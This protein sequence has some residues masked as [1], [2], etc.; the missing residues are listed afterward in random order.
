MPTPVQGPSATVT[1]DP[2]GF[3]YLKRDLVRLLGILGHGTKAVQD[4][5]RLCGGIHVVMNLC[6]VDE[7]NPCESLREVFLFLWAAVLSRQ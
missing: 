4:R 5:A 1:Q 2:T 3:S 7:R 6:V